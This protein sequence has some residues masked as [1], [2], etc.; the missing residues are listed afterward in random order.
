MWLQ[1]PPTPDA[2]QVLRINNFAGLTGEKNAVS[3][4][5]PDALEFSKIDF[6]YEAMGKEIQKNSIEFKH[7]HKHISSGFRFGN[8][9]SE[10][11]L[12]VVVSGRT[13]NFSI[14]TLGKHEFDWGDIKPPKKTYKL[15]RE[16]KEENNNKWLLKELIIYV[17]DKPKWLEAIDSSSAYPKLVI[18][19]LLL[20]YREKDWFFKKTAMNDGIAPTLILNDFSE[21]TAFRVSRPIEADNC[22]ILGIAYN[23]NVQEDKELGKAIPVED[24]DGMRSLRID[25][26][27]RDAYYGKKNFTCAPKIEII[28][29]VPE[30]VIPPK[31][32]PLGIYECDS[33]FVINNQG[34]TT[35]RYPEPYYKSTVIQPFSIE[36]SITNCPCGTIGGDAL[37]KFTPQILKVDK[38]HKCIER[39]KGEDET[40]TTD[41]LETLISEGE[42]PV[43]YTAQVRKKIIA[44]DT[45]YLEID[46]IAI[47]NNNTVFVRNIDKF[48]NGI[49]PGNYS[50]ELISKKTKKV[51]YEEPFVI[52]RGSKCPEQYV[53]S[54]RTPIVDNCLSTVR[55]E[56]KY[57]PCQASV[58]SIPI[59]KDKRFL[60]VSLDP[61]DITKLEDVDVISFDING[62]LIDFKNGRTK[63]TNC[64]ECKVYK[65]NN[66]FWSF[67]KL[68]EGFTGKNRLDQP[69]IFD[70]EKVGKKNI[71]FGLT[72]SKEDKP[73]NVYYQYISLT[74]TNPKS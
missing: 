60:I 20:G 4:T 33:T 16:K 74:S 51:I 38:Y 70:L 29:E 5:F 14:D 30:Q 2:Y 56:D 69:L 58:T 9:V 1:N 37:F 72:K 3:I 43:A 28:F 53:I 57:I 68:K 19:N 73:V 50:L 41:S 7:G 8:D 21:T 17:E 6:S 40:Y 71:F 36:S 27:N 66:L 35:A 48:K 46:T 12:K 44:E 64:G 49:S 62:G 31:K 13:I 52:N 59:L 39:K 34:D 23:G 42:M 47:L 63:P 55:Y 61:E 15:A 11:K 45:S 54:E 22:G 10:T 65:N 67:S 25:F 32:L 24:V 18:E 26:F